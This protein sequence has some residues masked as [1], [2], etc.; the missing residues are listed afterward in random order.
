MQLIIKITAV[1]VVVI[2]L[3]AVFSKK[4]VSTQLVIPAA[5][6]T[7]WAV[8]M[9][10]QGYPQWN[11]VLIPLE[12]K[13]ALGNTLKYQWTPAGGEPIEVNSSVVGFDEPQQLRQKGGTSGVLT[14]EHSYTLTA[15]D[16]GTLLQQREVY[17]GVGVWFWDA[18]QM[19]PAYQA[20][21]EA[22]SQRVLSL[23]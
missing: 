11:P 13:L 18:S 4:S 1:V 3:L 15:V 6:E 8:L 10:E 22:L 9:D 2:A 12:G 23:Q 7:I 17:R 16:G 5:P 19:Q 14:F 20:V 21:N